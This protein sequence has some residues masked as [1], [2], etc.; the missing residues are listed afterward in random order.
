MFIAGMANHD[1]ASRSPSQI[2]KQLCH[3]Y[4]E[5]VDPIFK[6]LHQPSLRSFMLDDEAYLDYK[7]GDPAPAA[8]ACAVC[9][10]AT[11]SLSEQQCFE[12]FRMNKET[13][14][15][16]HQKET[17][18]A[19]LRADFITS[20]DLTVLQAFA[21]S[22]VSSTSAVG[23]A[24]DAEHSSPPAPMIGAAESGLCWALPSELPKHCQSIFLALHSKCDHLRTKCGSGY[25]TQSGLS[26]RYSRWTI[27]PNQ[28]CSQNGCN[29][30]LHPTSTTATFHS[31]WKDQFENYQA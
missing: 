23:L 14:V 1:N 31:T 7:P 30:I 5:Q 8:L 3:I 9:Y 11:C 22:L 25:G 6:T 29:P 10:V 12:L 4:L 13:M 27:C 16:I 26:T 17:E 21:L 19:L 20:N 2:Q 28:S 18:A 24:A 15:S